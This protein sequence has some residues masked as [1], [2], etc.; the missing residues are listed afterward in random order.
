M[1]FYEYRERRGES[2]DPESER[3]A[4]LVIGALIEVH[5]HLGPG[6]AE[7]SYRN[8]VCEELRVRNLSFACE[9]PVEV[10]YKGKIVGNGRIDLLVCGVLIVELKSVEQLTTVHKGQLLAYLAATHLRLGLLVNF[11]VER[12]KDGIKRVVRDPHPLPS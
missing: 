3:V 11:N 5:K 7:I 6:H 10:V 1:D 12:L 4:T 2:A 9:V 8:A